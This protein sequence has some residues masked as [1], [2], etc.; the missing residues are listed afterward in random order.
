MKCKRIMESEIIAKLL[1]L[2]Y[3]IE[4]ARQSSKLFLP[5][6]LFFCWLKYTIIAWF[7]QD[8][9]NIQWKHQNQ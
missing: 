2:K 5:E 6:K 4:V 3:G 9:G 1:A 8:H 7:Y